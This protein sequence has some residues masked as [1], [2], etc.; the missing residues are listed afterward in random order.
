MNVD[1]GTTIGGI[2]GIGVGMDAD[3]TGGGI[4]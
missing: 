2:S 4:W 1:V 3:R